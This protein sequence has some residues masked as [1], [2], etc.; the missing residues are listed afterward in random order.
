MATFYMD[1]FIFYLS[2]RTPCNKEAIIFKAEIHV[3]MAPQTALVGTLVRAIPKGQKSFGFK[4]CQFRH[5]KSIGHKYLV[6][7]S[8]QMG[9]LLSDSYP[10]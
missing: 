2:G 10:C 9:P 7:H 5:F 8:F 6:L 3:G 1:I 4:Y